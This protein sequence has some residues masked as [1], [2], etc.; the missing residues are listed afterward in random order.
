[1]GRAGK[2]ALVA[3]IGAAIVGE[4]KATFYGLTK[5]QMNWSLFQS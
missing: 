1:M 2:I 5:R 3:G 4:I